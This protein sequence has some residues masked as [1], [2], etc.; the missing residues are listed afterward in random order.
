MTLAAAPVLP[1]ETLEGKYRVERVLGRG[2]MG[3]VVAARHLALDEHVA[4]KFLLGEPSSRAV[5]RFLREARAAVKVKGEHVCRVFDFGRLDTGEPYIVMEHLEGTDLA[6]KLEREGAQPASRVVGW[7]V[8]A[9]DALAEAHAI[10]IVHRDLKPANVFLA[11]RSDG[12]TCAKVLDFGI[13]KL[14]QAETMT[15]TATTMGS[16]AYMAP[17][18]M[19]SSHDVDARADV[20][21]LG[22]M[23]YELL[24]AQPPFAGESMLQLAVQVRDHEPKP[25]ELLQPS[26][27]EALGRVIAKCL[28]KAPRDRYAGAWELASALAPHAPPEVAPLVARLAGR[29]STAPSRSDLALDAT[30]RDPHHDAGTLPDKSASDPETEPRSPVANALPAPQRG[31]FD[32]LQSTLGGEAPLAEPSRRWPLALGG[33]LALA[34][35]GLGVEALMSRAS[36]VAPKAA[37]SA[38]APVDDVTSVS[39]PASASLTAP[40]S[41][42]LSASAGVA[43]PSS[44]PSPSSS[45]GTAVEAGLAVA[46]PAFTPP[47]PAT[48]SPRT[49][50]SASPAVPAVPPVSG[51]HPRPAPVAPSPVTAPSSVATPPVVDGRKKRELDRED[52]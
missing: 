15:R 8:E 12:S 25:I 10:G 45:S 7:V 51:D 9:C 19:E 24:A 42:S 2:A 1:G 44:S 35:I 34:L 36:D 13:S 20:W 11:T 41:A 30:M 23:M 37:A 33:A 16:P 3:V 32:P 18:Q 6:R 50:R 29:V 4:I 21:S 46:A 52:P 40:A 17:E 31:T 14:P 26:V 43:S 48:A 38:V 5:D 22:V 28:A 49:A 47:A 27:P 39:A